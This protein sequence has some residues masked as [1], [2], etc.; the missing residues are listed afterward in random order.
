MVNSPALLMGPNLVVHASRTGK[1]RYLTKVSGTEN[2]QYDPTGCLQ[3]QFLSFDSRMVDLQQWMNEASNEK[4]SQLQ[5]VYLRLA[6][7]DD[8]AST[9]PSILISMKS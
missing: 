4:A 8:S 3:I 6:N 5:A 9:Y 2:V 1:K 7:T